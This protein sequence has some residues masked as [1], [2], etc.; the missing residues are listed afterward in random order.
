MPLEYHKLLCHHAF[1][2]TY[3]HE[4]TVLFN[5]ETR[6]YYFQLRPLSD[7][8]V[9][10]EEEKDMRLNNYIET[11][12]S[13]DELAFQNE[14]DMIHLSEEKYRFC[15]LNPEYSYFGNIRNKCSINPD[16]DLPF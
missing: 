3:F 14:L 8:P 2:D 1:G 6:K 10:T 12:Y 9:Y 15:Y 4:S 5:T 16:D 7:S 11:I 13:L